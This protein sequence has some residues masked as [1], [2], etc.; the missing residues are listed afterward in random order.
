MKIRPSLSAWQIY[1][2]AFMLLF[3]WAMM[4]VSALV[5]FIHV[6]A[7]KNEDYHPKAE[8]LI[9]LTWDDTA[10]IDLDLWLRNPQG[11]KPV[12]YQNRE[13]KNIALDRD[14][15]G[16]ISNQS[17]L[18]SGQL[19]NTGNREIISIRAIIPGDYVVAVTYYSGINKENNYQ[20]HMGVE[21]PAAKIKAKVQVDKVN[22]TVTPVWS[23]EQDMTFVKQVKTFVAFHINEDGSVKILP[24]PESPFLSEGGGFQSEPNRQ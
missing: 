4:V 21:D 1:A 6:Q 24:L 16:Y 3:M 11:S 7:K 9:T 20:F 5:L 23:G 2:D 8:Y 17:V 14:S 18:E 19:V 22:P 15:R 10:N 12:F 13:D